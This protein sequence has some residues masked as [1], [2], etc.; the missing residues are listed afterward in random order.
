MDQMIW[1][2][3][4]KA[5]RRA[6]VPAKHCNKAK[7]EIERAVDRYLKMRLAFYQREL[8]H[9][10]SIIESYVAISAS[11]DRFCHGLLDDTIAGSFIQKH[12]RGL[13]EAIERAAE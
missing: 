11:A 13:I 2:D 5:L 8:D 12:A 1:E 10:L 9:G 6:G 7:A 4:A 3:I